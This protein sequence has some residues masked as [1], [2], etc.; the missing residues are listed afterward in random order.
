MNHNIKQVEIDGEKIYLKKSPM[1]GWGVV[2]PLKNEDGSIHWKNFIGNKGTWISAFFIVILFL[3]FAYIYYHDTKEMQK[4]IAYPCDY[5]KTDDLIV[6]LNERMNARR[7][8]E[9]KPKFN[10]T[11]NLVKEG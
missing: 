2:Y 4:V 5:C 6:K 1:F 11:V 3:V 9:S 7:E 10:F 8:F